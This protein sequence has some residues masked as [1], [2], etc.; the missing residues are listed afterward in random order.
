MS[1]IEAAIIDE[2]R[3]AP[4]QGRRSVDEV[5]T[6]RSFAAVVLDDGSVGA[7]MDYAQFRPGAASSAAVTCRRGGELT[8][9]LGTS[10]GASLLDCDLL[11]TPVSDS[12]LTRQAVKIALLGA[13]SR[14]WFRDGALAATGFDHLVAS[15]DET[16]LHQPESAVTQA[17][18]RAVA[19]AGT[20]GVVGFGGL[21][22]HFADLDGVRR[23]LVADLH[24]APRADRI[25]RTLAR[26]NARFDEPRIQM[27]GNDLRRLA[28]ECDIVQITPSSL[29]NGTMDDLIQT[30][31][32]IPLIVVGPSGAVPPP[33]WQANDVVL[34]CTEIKDSRFVRAY[35]NDDHLYEWFVEYDRRL[36]YWPTVTRPEKSAGITRPTSR[37]VV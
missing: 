37:V 13:L 8:D 6:G 18:T 21:M 25:D 29:C 35:H 19:G 32:G 1:H 27:V 28:E 10:P 33:V 3:K 34:V 11:R 17:L 14:P 22:E 24:E 30:L 4:D 2:L 20:V 36:V 31:R 9:Y 23:V 12:D 5:L 7:A 15:F 16:H 26:F